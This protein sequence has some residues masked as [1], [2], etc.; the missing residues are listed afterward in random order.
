MTLYFTSDWHIGHK[1][2]RRLANRPFDD[3]FIMHETLIRNYQEII[4][5]DDVIY[6]LGDIAW[7]YQ[8]L[9]ALLQRLPGMKHL[10][11]GNHD[12]CF[13]EMHSPIS[14]SGKPIN[15]NKYRDYYLRA[16]F[17]SVNTTGSA[18]LI[19]KHHVLLNHFPYRI[20][21]KPT[22]YDDRY[23]DK[24][25]PFSDA[26]L[27]HGHI[28]NK[29]FMKARQVNISVEMWDYKPVSEYDISR[30]IEQYPEG[31]ELG[32]NPLL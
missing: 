19:G 6:F 2:I 8:S 30:L 9:P 15:T 25:L 31:A 3:D 17:E 21:P 24:R 4:T 22:D 14:T 16:G 12:K 23:W 28:H 7:N 18:I 29:G 1:N 26:W 27:I 13:K 5:D 20:E 11:V 32:S 10:I